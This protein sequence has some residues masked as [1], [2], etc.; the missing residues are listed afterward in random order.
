MDL[1]LV[2]DR[3]V[4]G[5]REALNRGQILGVH[6]FVGLLPHAVARMDVRGLDHESV[7]LPVAPRVAEPGP[8]ARGQSVRLAQSDDPDVVDHFRHDEHVV[9][10]LNDREVVVVP[11]G[12]CHGR[13]HHA[14]GA[15]AVEDDTALGER[16]KFGM[17]ELAEPG[18]DLMVFPLSPRA[19]R[20]KLGN[21]AV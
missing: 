2:E 5:P 12:G 1:E 7:A 17:V 18:T 8:D 9:G 16:P 13:P 11:S 10:V 3:V 19:F 6:D 14:G 4:L 21:P 20:R 15:R